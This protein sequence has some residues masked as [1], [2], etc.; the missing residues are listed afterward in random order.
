MSKETDSDKSDEPDDEFD[1]IFDFKSISRQMDDLDDSPI[2]HELVADWARKAME[3]WDKE[4]SQVNG[5]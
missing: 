3:S 4:W 2:Y 1:L 5:E